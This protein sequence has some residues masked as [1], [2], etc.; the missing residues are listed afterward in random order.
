MHVPHP[1]IPDLKLLGLPLKLSDTPGDIR[2]PPPLMG[3]HAE[4]I[5]KDLGYTEADISA[6]RDRK[7][8]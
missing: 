7:V 4:T 2:M 3:Q 8:I 6:L 5:L 1:C